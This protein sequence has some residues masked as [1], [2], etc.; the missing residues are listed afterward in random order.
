MWEIL[1][2]WASNTPAMDLGHMNL[3]SKL[4]ICV[5]EF[6]FDVHCC[7]EVMQLYV[8]RGCRDCNF[9]NYY[10]YVYVVF[11]LVLCFVCMCCLFPAFSPALFLFVF[12]F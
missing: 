12:V 6:F 11:C 1:A 8:G 9:L 5:L 2:G 10:Y 7:F 4:C 3:V